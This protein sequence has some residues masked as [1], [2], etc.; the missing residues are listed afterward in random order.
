VGA[1]GHS[2]FNLVCIDNANGEISKVIAR[3][4]MMLK[5]KA[6]FFLAFFWLLLNTVEI[7]Y[8]LID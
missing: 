8:K 4:V 2:R 7:I 3:G 1:K 5:E 6:G